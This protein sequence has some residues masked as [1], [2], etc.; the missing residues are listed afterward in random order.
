MDR[1][2]TIFFCAPCLR[3]NSVALSSSLF[4]SSLGVLPLLLAHALGRFS[5][6]GRSLEE[7]GSHNAA[8][9]NK[10]A[11]PF[12]KGTWCSGITPA[13]HAGGPGFNPQRVHLGSLRRRGQE[14]EI[15]WSQAARPAIM[16]PRHLAPQGCQRE[17]GRPGKLAG[18][19]SPWG[20]A[21]QRNRR[22]HP[23]PR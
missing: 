1:W 15:K 18:C 22:K 8:P 11:H 12:V 9:T 3:H 6:P 13:Q 17:H 21:V 20:A 7:M 19:R 14:R 5:C 16:A 23:S 2:N 10:S 4:S